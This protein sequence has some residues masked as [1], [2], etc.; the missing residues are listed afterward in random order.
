MENYCGNVR[1]LCGK[2]RNFRVHRAVNAATVTPYRTGICSFLSQNYGRLKGGSKILAQ[3]ADV[4]PRTV[5]NW[6]A[7]RCA[8]NGEQLLDLMANCQAIADEVLALVEER[9]RA[10]EKISCRGSD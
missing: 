10:R 2:T 6:F 7:G 1:T 4:S 9:R 5:D 3:T 8:P